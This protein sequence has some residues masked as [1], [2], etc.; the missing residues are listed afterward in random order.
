[1]K[2]KSR[3][4]GNEHLVHDACLFVLPAGHWDVVVWRG[5][6]TN[7]PPVSPKSVVLNA[8]SLASEITQYVHDNSQ[9]IKERI[10][11]EVIAEYKEKF[12]KAYENYKEINNEQEQLWLDKGLKGKQKTIAREVEFEYEKALRQE[13]G[14]P[15]KKLA[16]PEVN[17]LKERKQNPSDRDKALKNHLTKEITEKHKAQLRQ[18]LQKQQKASRLTSAQYI[19]EQLAKVRKET[20]TISVQRFKEY[21]S[22]KTTPQR[23]AELT[24]FLTYQRVHERPEAAKEFKDNG[25]SES[26]F[27]RYLELN[28]I[29]D[30]QK[31][32]PIHISGKDVSADYTQYHVDSVSASDPRAAYLGVLSSCCQTVGD[33]GGMC[34]EHGITSPNGG[35][36]ASFADSPNQ[37]KPTLM[38][39]NWVWLGTKD[40]AVIDSIESHINF[41]QLK[42]SVISDLHFYLAYQL[43]AYPHI[44]QIVCGIGDTPDNFGLFQLIELVLPLDHEGYRDSRNKKLV[45]HQDCIPLFM[46][47]YFIRHPESKLDRALGHDKPVTAKGIRL[48]VDLCIYNN[49]LDYLKLANP[50]LQ[51]AGMS[52]SAFEE[53]IAL[54]KEWILHLNTNEISAEKSSFETV[55]A[56]IEKGANPAFPINS[57]LNPLPLI[58]NY[59]DN[60]EQLE[61]LLQQGAS[62]DVLNPRIDGTLHYLARIG[63]YE[64]LQVILNSVSSL[65][66]QY[67]NEHSL[68]NKLLGQGR[69]ELVEL[70]LKKGATIN[71]QSFERAIERDSIDLFALLVKFDTANARSKYWYSLL[72]KVVLEERLDWITRLINFGLDLNATDENNQ[73]VLGYLLFQP[74]VTLQAKNKLVELGAKF[75]PG[76]YLPDFQKSIYEIAVESGL[77]EQAFKMLAFTNDLSAIRIKGKSLR[78]IATGY[79]QEDI[80]AHIDTLLRSE[81]PHLSVS[82]ENDETVQA[83]A[84]SL[85][86]LIIPFRHYRTDS[87]LTEVQ[88]S[89]LGSLLTLLEYFNKVEAIPSLINFWLKQRPA[90]FG[91]TNASIISYNRGFFNQPS[92]LQQAVMELKTRAEEAISQGKECINR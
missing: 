22:S 80:V 23:L 33:A 26:V 4:W 37:G 70:C 64:A 57:Y 82:F 51:R 44:V 86:Q 56:F 1:M 46:D 20:E 38:A 36:Y 32:P 9:K 47:A 39:Q 72:V 77:T 8:L 48:W 75:N 24:V 55:K 92:A 2:S 25:L 79:Q 31:I 35:F 27:N 61:W 54:T 53:Y 19:D 41:K 50:Y 58:R 74:M 85:E 5:I 68:L 49:Q 16:P 63:E 30:P 91:T 40:S 43:I 15:S 65:S 18:E 28:P 52:E 87:N 66:I 81:N 10:Q 34:A 21:L 45:L 76:A 67:E 84:E 11:Q 3:E 60:T 73:T 42:E 13:L 6:I 62:I 78:E 83:D 29:D 59:I 17:K 12:K 88:K 90:R 7:F 89:V 71:E 14:L 69:D